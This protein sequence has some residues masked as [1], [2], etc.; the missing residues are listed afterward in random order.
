M[1]LKSKQELLEVVRPRY[2]QAGK[3][4]KQNGKDPE[5]VQQETG[6]S[7]RFRRV[8]IGEGIEEPG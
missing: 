7:H 2:L 8:E 3:E 6:E 1:S 4:E 5:C